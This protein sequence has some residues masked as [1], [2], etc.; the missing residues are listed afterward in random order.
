MS[1]ETGYAAAISVQRRGW[2]V[3]RRG[4]DTGV[5]GPSH[6]ESAQVEDVGPKSGVGQRSLVRGRRPQVWP[7]S[8]P[9]TS[10]SNAHR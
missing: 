10:Y 1:W 4:A 5:G 3:E 2:L 9:Q 6:M 7:V 8:C